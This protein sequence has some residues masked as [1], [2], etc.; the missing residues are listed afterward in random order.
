MMSPSELYQYYL[1]NP[2]NQNQGIMGT[3]NINSVSQ[4]PQIPASMT[5]D[6]GSDDNINPNPPGSGITNNY[7]GLPIRFRDI[8]SLVLN[9]IYGIPNIVAR[10]NNYNSPI[11][12]AKRNFIGTGY[13]SSKEEP[14]L[15]LSPTELNSSGHSYDESGMGGGYNEGDGGSYTGAS[16]EDWGGG[17]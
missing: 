5:T 14:G 6:Q 2:Y 17:E 8:A 15:G 10:A 3:E 11:D 1:N 9:P 13:D 16:T 12:Y 7:N 4:V